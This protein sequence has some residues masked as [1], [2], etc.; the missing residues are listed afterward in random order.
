MPAAS[1]QLENHAATSTAGINLLKGIAGEAAG[2]VDPS[3][4]FP[5]TASWTIGDETFSKDLTINAVEPT[6]LGEDLPAGTVVTITEG[7]APAFDT[8]VWGAITISGDDVTDNGDGSA[9]IVVSDQQ[10]AVTLATVTNEA[11]WAP[12]TF[13]LSKDVT[14]VLLDNPDVPDAVTV[15][16]TWFV[17][18][19]RVSQD[20]TVPTDGTVVPFG[21]DLPHGTAVTLSETALENAAA[22]TW[23]EPAWQAEGIV[24][25]D[26]G[27]ATITIG[28]AEDTAVTLTNQAVASLG[29][30]QLG[31]TLSGE[32]ASD[33][34]A[35]TVF[36][37]VATWTDLTGAQ[38]RA[39]MQLK[40]GEPVV[41]ADLPLGTEVTLTEGEAST[42]SSVKWVGATWS[43]DDENVTVSGD[44]AEVI[45]TVTGEP[46]TAAEV[47]LD[48]EFEKVPE[49][50]T[51]G[52]VLSIGIIAL[53]VG[54]V[55]GGLLLMTVRRRRA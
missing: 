43:S 29:R 3:T 17:D 50:A 45:V 41:L 42:P 9:E 18:G 16:A 46:G 4:G 21:A 2:E 40:A 37:V 22:F 51:T 34:P 38:Q 36:P 24:V 32:G 52:G 44:G 54:L 31:K 13:S 23:A 39:E 28:A 5:V 35:D 1:V 25:N 26:D 7:D 27:T 8:V 15:T 47:G 30:L 6:P 20:I 53:A 49:L 33:V 12:G 11:T 48:N 55:G 19:E 10:G 14:G